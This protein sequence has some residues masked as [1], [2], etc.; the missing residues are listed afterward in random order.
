MSDSFASRTNRVNC[1]IRSLSAAHAGCWTAPLWFITNTKQ[2]KTIVPTITHREARLRAATSSPRRPLASS[3]THSCCTPSPD[4]L[5]WSCV[6]SDSRSHR[7]CMCA[8]IPCYESIRNAAATSE[9]DERSALSRWGRAVLILCPFPRRQSRCRRRCSDCARS[10]TPDPLG[11]R[12]TLRFMSL[13]S[14][15]NRWDVVLVLPSLS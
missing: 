14:F 8:C 9:R 12:A 7:G 2:K 15:T 6:R 3:T 4:T 11:S 1:A 10:S 5:R 13:K